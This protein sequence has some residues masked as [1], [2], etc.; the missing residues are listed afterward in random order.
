MRVLVLNRTEIQQLLPMAECIQVMARTLKTLGQGKAANPLR[1]VFFLP[2]KIGVLAMMPAY[3]GEIEMM[4]VK[5]ISVFTHEPGSEYDSH[6]GVVLLFETAHGSLRA[7]VDAGEITRIRT[8][9]VSAVA[10]DLLAR[11]DAVD[12][13]ILGSGVQAA[14]H[15]EAMLEVRKI[16]RVRVWSR[17]LKNAQSFARQQSRLHDV[18]IKAVYT[19]REAV[20]NADI[21]C[22]TTASPQ[23]VLLGEWIAPGAHI[24]AVGSS[25]PFAR[26][27]DT[28]A[29]VKSRLF[30]DRRES[31]LN[32][33]GDF[34]FPQKEGAIGDDHIQGEIGEILLNQVAG[35]ETPEE[36]TLFKSLGLAVE[37]LASAY[38][39]YSKAVNRDIGV[40]VEM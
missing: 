15:L 8:A 1:N 9:A 18:P 12:L 13:A 14:S 31:T 26:E 11:P 25:I 21:I 17:T 38:Y 4:G 23:P 36:L 6:Q 32:E 27:L 30:V 7:I 20:E 34:L 24:N 33:A 19:A 2:E 40:W 3:D 37:D 22:T 35:R 28:A 29:V 16:Q 10:T 39:A 5:T